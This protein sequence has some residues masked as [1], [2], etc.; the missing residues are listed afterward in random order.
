MPRSVRAAAGFLGVVGLSAGLAVSQS[1]AQAPQSPQ[2]PTFRTGINVVR[3]DV[4]VSDRNGQAALDLRQDEFEIT[5]SGKPQTVETFKLVKLD[6]G[7]A[8]AREGPPRAIRSDSVEEMEAARDDVR[9]FAI[10]LDD[11]HVRRL[12]AA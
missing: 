9:L 4:I 7:V 11:Y 2:Q 10:F 6:G 5:E 1:T 12:N 3:V 8:E